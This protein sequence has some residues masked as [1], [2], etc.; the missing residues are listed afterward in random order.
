[1]QGA[2]DAVDSVDNARASPCVRHGSR[3]EMQAEQVLC[4][5]RAAMVGVAQ[6]GREVYKRRQT[7]ILTHEQGWVA[8]KRCKE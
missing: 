1:V 8:R 2:K 6:G 7:F 5:V 4:W 3:C